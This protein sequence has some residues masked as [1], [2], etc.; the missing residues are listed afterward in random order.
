M[1]D[2]DQWEVETR[3]WMRSHLA[4]AT[5][6]FAIT[7]AGDPLW[8]WCLR[9]ISAPVADRDHHPHWLRV[10]VERIID[11]DEMPEFWRGL[12]D[13]NAVTNVPKPSVVGSVEWNEPERGQRV[14]AD[15]MTRVTGRPCSPTE[16]LSVRL[17][18]PECWW[19]QLRAAVDA[20][21]MVPTERYANR[22][23]SGS[24]LVRR[25]FGD[26]V[27]GAY[28]PIETVHGDLHWNNLLGPDLVMLDWELW[29]RGPVGT[30]AATLY[31]FALLV[32][33]TAHRVHDLFADVLDT[34]AGRIAQIG[35]AS[36]ILYRANQHPQLAN[37]VREHVAP[38]LHPIPTK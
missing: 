28:R 15:L 27:A 32:P 7:L 36:G 30:D 4:R 8:G 22:S 25:V 1:D 24:G 5:N 16:G 31:L 14:R 13:A 23:G 2:G 10:G 11:I 18:V 3:A 17:A 26:E 19:D 12:V 34:P 29:G 38:L 20:I 21:R 9:S 35:V 6:H 33:D 37:A